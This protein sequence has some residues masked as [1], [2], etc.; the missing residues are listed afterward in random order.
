MLQGLTGSIFDK[1][2]SKP[3]NADGYYSGGLGH[4]NEIFGEKI[5]PYYS[6]F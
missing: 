3:Y 4:T 1:N 2:S 6:V 5:G